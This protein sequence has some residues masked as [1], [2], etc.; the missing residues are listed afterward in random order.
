MSVT[1]FSVFSPDIFQIELKNRFLSARKNYFD[2]RRKNK[3]LHNEQITTDNN[4]YNTRNYNKTSTNYNTTTNINN[5]NIRDLISAKRKSKLKKDKKNFQQKY[6]LSQALMDKIQPYKQYLLEKNKIEN[7][8]KEKIRYK[9]ML[10]NKKDLLVLP[11]K[12]KIKGINFAKQKGFGFFEQYAESKNYS[13]EKINI[14]RP[15]FLIRRSKYEDFNLDLF[16]DIKNNKRKK[17]FEENFSINSYLR[18]DKLRQN[19]ISFLKF[20]DE[21]PNF[22]Y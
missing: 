6:I 7:I 11:D 17:V 2:N 10:R 22:N 21:S 1:Y 3:N 5:T 18:Y 16:E 14:K 4:I 9:L 15:T 8:K 20:L 13:N 19:A 12:S